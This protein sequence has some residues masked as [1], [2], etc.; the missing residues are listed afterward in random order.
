MN[1]VETGEVDGGAGDLL[2][3]H[4]DR[5][6]APVL[7]RSTR[8]LVGFADDLSG[9]RDLRLYGIAAV[10]FAVVVVVAARGRRTAW[11]A[12]AGIV[13]VGSVPLALA[14]T[15][16]R[17][18]QAHEKLWLTLG[19]RDLAF[20]D[21]DRDASSPSTVFSYFGPLGFALVLAG[22][23]VVIVARRREAAPRLA[24]LLALAPVL[25]V[26]YSPRSRSCTT[27]GAGASSSTGSRWRQRRGVSYSATA[28]WH[29]G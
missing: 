17:L 6:P 22:V 23:I 28:G 13:A 7:A 14:A 8:M 2:E 20:L 15:R 1:L 16:E 10:A 4:P 12:A 5:S 29:G 3:Q 21:T 19:Q 26:R 11:V 9:G 18:L 27:L 24:L 25:M